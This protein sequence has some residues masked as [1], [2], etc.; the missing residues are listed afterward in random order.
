MLSNVAVARLSLCTTGVCGGLMEW[1]DLLNDPLQA[2]Q[3]ASTPA[4]LHLRWCESP[5][6]QAL[7]GGAVQAVQVAGEC[8]CHPGPGTLILIGVTAGADC[9]VQ[10]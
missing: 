1:P 4:G 5:G 8:H 3:E 6:L 9:F 7:H 2:H 10:I